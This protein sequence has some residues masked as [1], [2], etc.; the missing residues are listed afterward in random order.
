M[1]ILQLLRYCLFRDAVL[2]FFEHTDPISE[3]AAFWIYILCIPLRNVYMETNQLL[4]IASGIHTLLSAPTQTNSTTKAHCSLFWEVAS[5]SS[6]FKLKCSLFICHSCLM[7]FYWKGRD[8]STFDMQIP[9]SWSGCSLHSRE[10]VWHDLL[11][12]NGL[13]LWK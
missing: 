12:T 11:M 8:R 5:F 10:C 9:F 1:Y 7:C 2:Y 4:F 13:C 3:M 6:G